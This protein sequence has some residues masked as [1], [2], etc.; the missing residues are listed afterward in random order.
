MIGFSAGRR[1]RL[2]LARCLL[3]GGSGMLIETGDVLAQTP[4]RFL[5]G[6]MHQGHDQDADAGQLALQAM[7]NEQGLVP[8]RYRVQ[9]RLNQQYVGEHDIEFINGGSAV[10]SACLTM[11]LL[12]QFGVNT[13]SVANPETLVSPCV[14]LAILIPDARADFDAPRL[15]LNLSV[16]QIAMHRKASGYVDPQ[17]WEHGINAAFV[18]YQVSAQQGDTRYS[19]RSDSQ[20]LLLNGGINLGPWRLRSNQSA[21][22]D[23]DGGRTWTRAY[24]YA[25]RDL[26]G[27]HANLTVGEA[28]SGGDV[29]KSVALKGV[30]LKSDSGML[31]DVMQNYSP[32]I[33]G[34]A[35]S[36]ARLE[37]RQSGYPIYSTYVSA[38]PFEIDDLNTGGGSGELEILLTE[39]DGQVRRF[40]QPYA[41]LGN[42]LRENTWKYS[43]AIGRYNVAGKVEDPMLWQGTLASG[44][45][46]GTT[47]YGGLQTSEHYQAASLGAAKDL[48]AIGALALDVT[49]SSAAIDVQ[50]AGSVQGLS[51]A[52]KYGKS[53][54]SRTSLRF[55]GYRYSTQGY[56]DFDEAV[57]QRSQDTT[58]KGSRRSRLEASIYQGI[59]Q[60]SALTFTLFQEDFW[61]T[62]QQQRQ[63]QLNFNTRHRSVNYSLYA[64]QSLRSRQQTSDRQMGL[65]VSFPLDIG[66][67]SSIRLDTQKTGTSW[68]QRASVTGSLDQ[69]RLGYRAGIVN[70]NHRQ[71]AAELSMSYQMPVGNFGAGL[72]YG[73][74]YRN[75]SV[76]GAGAIVLHGEGV[77]FG[78]YLGETAALIEVPGIKDVGIANA[79]GVRTNARGFA[80]VP[81]LRP[82]RINQIELDT[83]ELGPEIELE[84]GTTQVVPRRGAL[85]K[86]TF[87]ARSVLRVVVNATFEGRPLPFGARLESAEGEVVGIV[88]QGGQALLSTHAQPQVLSVAWGERPAQQCRLVIDPQSLPSS[89]GY[90][91]QTAICR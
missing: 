37:I 33:R 63:F 8:G 84:N 81:Y 18:N 28:Y 52:I 53:F 24:T 41:S 40:T 56:R 73:N 77:E 86:R 38:G 42:L 11:A 25:Q 36:R 87:A 90:R 2:R 20:D 64:G 34:V 80:L 19:G 1:M 51:Y 60:Q 50:D 74:A 69:N 14:E 71:Q 5:S 7:A 48:G 70:E 89:R 49:R 47:L 79:P 26:P 58:F 78:P 59:G 17:R 54:D 88:G 45:G 16:P 12:D 44:I 3:A 85:V 46:W 29:F 27:L 82:Y 32:I 9:V 91:L 66:H 30:M 39:A 13:K 23:S 68:S 75:L 31:P 72:N 10:L 15:Q 61:R 22:Q 55:A 62:D 43:A 4:A 83:A 76:N 6:F 65:S 67:T 57:R 21:R 35:F